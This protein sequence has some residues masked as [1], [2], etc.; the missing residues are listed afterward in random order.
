M[1]S[2][3]ILRSLKGRN[4]YI[5]DCLESIVQVVWHDYELRCHVMMAC[6][7][8][9]REKHR[10]VRPR[11]LLHALKYKAQA[12]LQAPCQNVLLSLLTDKILSPSGLLD[13]EAINAFECCATTVGRLRLKQHGYFIGF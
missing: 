4:T 11:L 1:I 5:D 12:Y 13:D 2:P 10:P 9:T 7:T 8:Q 6:L 3:Q